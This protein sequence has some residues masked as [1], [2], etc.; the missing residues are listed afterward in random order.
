MRSKIKNK[1]NT[2]IYGSNYNSLIATDKYYGLLG[3][4]KAA[5]AVKKAHRSWFNVDAP[6]LKK[7]KNIYNRNKRGF[8]ICNGPSLNSIDLE[9]L[10]NEITIGVNA[11][12]LNFERMGFKPT[13]YIVEDNLV[14]ED[15]K[16]DINQIKGTIK[17]FAIRLAYCLIRDEETIFLN[18]SPNMN[19]W[20]KQREKFGTDMKFS[21][22]ASIATFGGNTVTYTSLQIAY[23]L[24]LREI[25]I[26]GADHDYK[27]PERYKH[28]DNDKNYV[29]DPLEKDVN[30][31]D[32]SYFGKGYRWHNP[33]VHKIEKAYKNAKKFFEAKGGKIF[34]ATPGGKL[35]VFDRVDY[36]KLFNHGYVNEKYI[37]FL[38]LYNNGGVT[39]FDYKGSY[40]EFKG[41]THISDNF[42]TNNKCGYTIEVVLLSNTT[43]YNNRK[44]S[45]IYPPMPFSVPPLM[46]Y[47]NGNEEIRIK[48]SKEFDYNFEWFEINTWYKIEL[49][50]DKVSN[51]T[52]LTINGKNVL[53]KSFYIALKG[54]Y[55]IGKGLKNR[56]WSGKI[57][58]LKIKEI[59]DSKSKNVVFAL[60]G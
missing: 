59:D 29:I 42:I 20:P 6:K 24:G 10:K 8:I 55:S 47:Q 28:M 37:D 49:M 2:A 14:A 4:L 52:T 54:N 38:S 40:K 43:I 16:D 12:Y 22:D 48:L 51:K 58:Y 27:V 36:D 39:P 30:H 46:V 15:R 45:K 3:K 35:E 1:I 50:G 23:H 31:F 13:Y 9:K 32:S 19:P 34:N 11:I 21:E 56:F 25:Y 7:L 60:N 26:V 41:D 57:G 17:L 53:E 33:K 18:H 44:Y 5:V